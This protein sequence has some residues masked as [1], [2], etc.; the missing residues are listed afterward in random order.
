MDGVPPQL[1]H[2]WDALQAAT[3]YCCRASKSARAAK[4]GR[5]RPGDKQGCLTPGAC[6]AMTLNSC[7]CCNAPSVLSLDRSVCLGVS[8]A[9]VVCA[10]GGPRSVGLTRNLS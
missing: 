4:Q 5:V 6:H 8:A 9:L 2:A 1:R 3:A 10:R 7:H